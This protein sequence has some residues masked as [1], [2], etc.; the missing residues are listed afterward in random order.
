[1]GSVKCLKSRWSYV[2]GCRCTACKAANAAYIKA[3]RNKPVK[4]VFVCGTNVAYTIGGCRCELCR[5]NWTEYMRKYRAARK[6][7]KQWKPKAAEHGTR[8]KFMKGCRCEACKKA[9]RLYK[10]DYRARKK[11][12]KLCL[13]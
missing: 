10:R 1:M 13:T 11:E 7:A 2:Q 4:R 12:Q 3:Q 6:K 8:S 9:D 5:A